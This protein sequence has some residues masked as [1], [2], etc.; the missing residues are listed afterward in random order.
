MIMAR[1]ILPDETWE[2]INP[3]LPERPPQPKGGRPALSNRD[4]LTGVL[5][6]LRMRLA[7]EDLPREMGCGCGMTCARRLREWQQTG[8]W[9]RIEDVLKRNLH[10]AER[11]DWP[12]AWGRGKPNDDNLLTGG[13]EG[14]LREMVS[15]YDNTSISKDM[16]A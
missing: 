12:R 6:V 10:R 8:V 13:R 1:P 7:W 3:L 2:L 16:E 9:P 14:F 11:Y 4:A 15:G 5:F